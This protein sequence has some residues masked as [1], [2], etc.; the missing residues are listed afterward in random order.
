MVKNKL[1][2]DEKVTAIDGNTLVLED[3]RHVELPVNVSGFFNDTSGGE[4]RV[5]EYYD[6]VIVEHTTTR[7]GTLGGSPGSGSSSGAS[8][9]TGGSGTG[10]AGTSGTGTS[11]SG[12]SGGTGTGGAGTSGS[13]TGGVNGTVK[14]N[15]SLDDAIMR[16]KQRCVGGPLCDLS[17]DQLKD[18]LEN[19]SDPDNQSTVEI[20]DRLQISKIPRFDFD[21]VLRDRPLLQDP[22]ALFVPAGLAELE[23][24]VPNEEW[25]LRGFQP[26][27]Y[28]GLASYDG[29]FITGFTYGY[30]L[31]KTKT[32]R[33]R[34]AGRIVASV[35]LGAYAGYGVGVRL[36]FETTVQLPALRSSDDPWMNLSV[37]VEPRNLDA[38]AYRDAGIGLHQ[39]FDGKELVLKSGVDLWATAKVLG[40]TVADFHVGKIL[41]NSRDFTPPLG[42]QRVDFGRLVFHGKDTGLWYGSE[43]FYTE[44]N[45]GVEAVVGGR[46]FELDVEPVH[47]RHAPTSL[48]FT[49]AGTQSFHVEA[50]APG[51]HE[52]ENGRY[53]FY[54]V[55]LDNPRYAPFVDLTLQF[56]MRAVL[57]TKQFGTY[58]VDVP[59]ID[60]YSFDV[61]LPYLD[62]HEGTMRSLHADQN[63]EYVIIHS[64]DDLE[65]AMER[66]AGERA[67]A[68][69]ALQDVVDVGARVDQ[70]E[71]ARLNLYTFSGEP[72][73]NVRIED[74][75]V[76]SRSCKY[77]FNEADYNIR[78][79]SLAVLRA[80]DASVRRGF[81]FYDA[82]LQ[83]VRDGDVKIESAEG[84][85]GTLATLASFGIRL[86][87]VSPSSPVG[88]QAI[89]PQPEPPGFDPNAQA[90][91]PQ[92]EPPGFDPNAQA[93][94]PQPEP[95]GFDPNAQAINPQP[96]PP[97]FH[98]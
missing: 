82:F 80:M 90:I 84:G 20:T 58:D 36:P 32:V 48:T 60:L 51:E 25:S 31:T 71:D 3:G 86:G 44:G 78:F 42:N 33:W 34:F 15:L 11:G 29:L 45:I 8:G 49:T 10:G 43:G 55:I 62:R 98:G 63:K 54:G 12:S 27:Q 26:L 57:D 40:S 79:R 56:S 64:L 24:W 65:D 4:T 17:P 72:I 52:D 97:G 14:F 59:W 91:N 21:D 68:C 22:D 7:P 88:P 73:G 83:G 69:A 39:L 70:L 18:L 95:P 92:P 1:L 19:K 76:T 61:N 30:E 9:T 37:T 13:G 74:H 35:E 66:L 41:D 5:K 6:R 28:A 67:D 23:P 89:N 77:L 38:D 50:N 93:I 87:L 16:F 75:A 2:A 47:L 96:E 85:S 53:G 81:S 46:S 94:N